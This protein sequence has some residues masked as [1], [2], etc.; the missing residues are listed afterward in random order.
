[1]H[2][3]QGREFLEK[4]GRSAAVM[5]EIIHI[6][7][8]LKK[9]LMNRSIPRIEESDPFMKESEKE[10][11]RR[12]TVGNASSSAAKGIVN[13]KFISRFE[14]NEIN[15]AF[16]LFIKEMEQIQNLTAKIN[17]NGRAIKIQNHF[18]QHQ[19]VDKGRKA[20]DMIGVGVSHDKS[21]DIARLPTQLLDFLSNRSWNVD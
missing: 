2:P 4:P 20:I 10:G 18:F 16:D 8:Q 7:G 15:P 5:D 11:E 17:S 9:G 3:F 1:M 19:A 6:L 14:W 13:R 12:L 21:A